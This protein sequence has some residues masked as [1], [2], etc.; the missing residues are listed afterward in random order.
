MIS[1]S[2][3]Q[4]IYLARTPV[5]MRKQAYG[6]AQVVESCLQRDPLS[7]DVF[8]FGNRQGTI[9][10]ILMWDV[11]GYWVAS[12]RLEQGRFGF[13]NKRGAVGAKGALNLSVAEAMNIIEGVQVQRAVYA[14]HY[15]Y[16]PLDK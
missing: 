12:K 7:G 9:I 13:G 14:Q 1:L 16:F 5:D 15:G 2:H 3:I 8:L 11:S 4:R 10:K 6:L